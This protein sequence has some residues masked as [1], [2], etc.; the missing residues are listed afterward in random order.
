MPNAEF[1][2]NATDPKSGRFTIPEEWEGD[3]KKYINALKAKS[4][5][6]QTK[7]FLDG[8]LGHLGKEGFLSDEQKTALANISQGSK[9]D[10]KDGGKVKDD[11]KDTSSGATDTSK[12]KPKKET[13]KEKPDTSKKEKP[14]KI[15]KEAHKEIKKQLGSLLGKIG[16]ISKDMASKIDSQA[17]DAIDKGVAG[18]ANVKDATSSVLDKIKADFQKKKEAKEIEKKK[19]AEAKKVKKAKKESFSYRFKEY[20]K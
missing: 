16:G 4:P 2:F 12:E 8:L 3:T 1:W 9:G 17:V 19:K 20:I 10:S 7:K 13:K 5:N 18:G 14:K 11:A 15:P 6:K